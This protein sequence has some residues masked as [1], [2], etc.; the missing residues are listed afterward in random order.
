MSFDYNSLIY[1]RTQGDV[2]S[3]RNLPDNIEFNKGNYNYVD[4]NRVESACEDLVERLN[5]YGYYV[6]INTKTNWTEDDMPYKHEIDRIKNNIQALK[7]AYYVLTT[8]PNVPSTST[9]KMIYT[10]ANDM[11]KILVDI[12]YLIRSMTQDFVYCGV[13]NCGQDRIWQQRFRRKR[14]WEGIPFNTFGDMLDMVA[15]KNI[16]TQSD[17]I[18]MRYGNDTSVYGNMLY[19][20]NKL[21]QLDEVIGGNE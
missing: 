13:C 20:N 18:E 12:D 5:S 16:A 19:Y 4:L 1:D 14:N 15:V 2:T 3:A 8:T 11:E 9:S 7:D 6:D 17:Q 21:N 10:Q